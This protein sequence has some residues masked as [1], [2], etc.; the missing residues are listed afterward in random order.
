MNFPCDS[1]GTPSTSM[2][3]SKNFN[4]IRFVSNAVRSS[5]WRVALIYMC[6]YIST[7][8]FIDQFYNIVLVT[9]IFV[10]LFKV[11]HVQNS[12]IAGI[13]V[14]RTST[15]YNI[16]VVHMPVYSGSTL[17]DIGFGQCNRINAFS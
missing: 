4:Y 6:K 17:L 2:P 5:V 1:S 12:D 13:C 9:V 14:K 10:Y 11:V 16:E 7:E 15:G 3:S 8:F